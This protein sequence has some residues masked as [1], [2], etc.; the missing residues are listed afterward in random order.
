[1]RHLPNFG[2]LSSGKEGTDSSNYPFS[3]NLILPAG[4]VLRNEAEGVL[5]L[6]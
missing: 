5:T 2:R 1:M 4:K 6:K 3:M